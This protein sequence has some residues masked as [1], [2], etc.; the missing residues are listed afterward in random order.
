MIPGVHIKPRDGAGNSN[1]FDSPIQMFN[2]LKYVR[3]KEFDTLMSPEQILLQNQGSCH[4]QAYFILDELTRQ[5][6]TP[7]G[8]FLLAVYP[9]GHG[10]ETHSFVYFLW[11][12]HLCWAET[13][14][15][16]YYGLNTFDSEQ[17]LLDYV[18]EAFTDRNMDKHIL[19]GDFNP[20]EHKVGED[21]DTLVNICLRSAS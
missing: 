19:L 5:G 17:E 6:Y 7:K 11:G 14:W 18:V 12:K 20:K 10:G 4:D 3:Y 16:E 15:E 21:L 9:D 2:F 13:S 8:K 1:R